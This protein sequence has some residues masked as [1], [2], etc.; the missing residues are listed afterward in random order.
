MLAA[1]W[2]RPAVDCWEHRHML[3]SQVTASSPF[4]YLLPLHRV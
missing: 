1:F 2:T 4:R 3:C